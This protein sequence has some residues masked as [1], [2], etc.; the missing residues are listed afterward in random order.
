MYHS[1]W[2]LSIC[3][4]KSQ[5]FYSKHNFYFHNST[6]YFKK[7]LITLFIITED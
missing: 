7:Y 3:D 1:V 4:K 6:E 2:A 5:Q